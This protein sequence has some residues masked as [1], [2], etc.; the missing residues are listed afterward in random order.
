MKKFLLTIA[1]VS[2]SAF[3]FTACASGEDTVAEE[4]A[5]AAEE[6]VEPVVE[7]PASEEVVAEDAAMEVEVDAAAEVEVE[8]VE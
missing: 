2:M 6:V 5:P 4:E 8:A 1:L 7:E 3:L